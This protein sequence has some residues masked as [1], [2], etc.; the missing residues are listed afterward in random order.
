MDHTNPLDYE[1][2][3]KLVGHL[4]LQSRIELEQLSRESAHMASRLATAERERN[5]ALAL[6]KERAA[7]K[8]KSE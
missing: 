7:L 6:L 2:V 3:C 8:E 4:Y 1:A 5:D